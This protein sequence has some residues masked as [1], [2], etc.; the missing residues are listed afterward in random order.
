VVAATDPFWQIQA[1]CLVRRQKALAEDL[2][3]SSEALSALSRVHDTNE[4]FRKVLD[5]VQPGDVVVD[6][7]ANVGEI[8][9][10]FVAKGC[11][12]HA[13][14][15]DPMA[16]KILRERF[17]ASSS[18]T[19]RE[20]AVG[21]APGRAKLY[22]HRERQ[23]VPNEVELT[24]SSSL[25]ADK[26]NVSNADYTEVEVVDLGNFITGL[27][28]RVAVLKVD[29][30]GAEGEILEMILKRRL[31]ERFDVAFFETHENKVPSIRPIIARV[32]SELKRLNIG[33]IYL[34]WK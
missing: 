29:V 13:F 26:K 30:E 28:A 2:M 8:V 15:P 14:E 3:L 34:D 9:K 7:G 27:G 16:C 22:Y 11:A 19:I 32:R 5:L 10:K 1:G 20:V 21:S 23:N 33:N 18:V 31:Y 6:C 17:G 24:Q 4:R 25:V 12:V